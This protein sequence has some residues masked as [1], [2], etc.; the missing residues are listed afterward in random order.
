MAAETEAVQKARSCCAVDKESF[1]E[2][3]TRKEDYEEVLAACARNVKMGPFTA[4]SGIT[5]EYYLNA[6]TNLL[7]KGVALKCTRLTLDLIK[8]RFQTSPGASEK[9]LVVGAEM[10]GGVMV[11]QCAAVAPLTH[12]DMLEWCDFVY[13]RKKRKESG[14]MQQLEGPNHITGRSPESPPCRGVLLD[15]ANSTGGSLLEFARL[16]KKDYNIDLAGAVYLV[17]RAKDRAELPA[18]K[19]GMANPALQDTKVLA[20]F[21]LEAVD[22][23]VPKKK[24]KLSE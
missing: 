22:A 4:T 20:L 7:D 23:L 12:P 17:D 21:G 15:D 13:C 11:G 14:T 2:A 19:L 24:P 1:R 5:L 6:A 3:L 9:L 10:A 8:Q 18:Q 16:L